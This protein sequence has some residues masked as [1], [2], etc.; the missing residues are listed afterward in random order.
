[1]NPPVSK[2]RHSELW[3]AVDGIV[4]ELK[5]TGEIA[6]NTAPNYV[7]DYICRELIAKKLI[8]DAGLQEQA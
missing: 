7:I 8:T 5:T 4:T 6:V 3:S 2:H 1:M